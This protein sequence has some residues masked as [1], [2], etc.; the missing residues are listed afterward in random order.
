MSVGK[1][2]WY[3][4]TLE[5]CCLVTKSCPTLATPQTVA[6]QAPLSVGF[7]RQE[8]CTGLPFP[9]LGDLLQPGT[10]LESPALA[11]RFFTT[12]PAGKPPFSSGQAQIHGI[13]VHGMFPSSAWQLEKGMNG[14][15]FHF[16]FWIT[17][18]SGRECLGPD[19]TV[20]K[21]ICVCVLAWQAAK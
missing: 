20:Q 17:S 15:S 7:P 13:Q 18:P 8:Y 6:R 11:G 12:E 2:N 21:C 10:E 9:S 1:Q 5:Y 14:T 16:F 4:H 19:L 3:I